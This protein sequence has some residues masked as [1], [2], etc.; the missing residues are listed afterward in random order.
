MLVT[1]KMAIKQLNVEIVSD[2]VTTCEIPNADGS[3]I[4]H[5]STKHYTVIEDVLIDDCEVWKIHAQGDLKQIAYL[6]EELRNLKLTHYAL[7]EM[8]RNY[9]KYDMPASKEILADR[10]NCQFDMQQLT[11]NPTYE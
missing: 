1:V 5:T 9:I 2:K 11:Y 8:N 7:L 10:L 4:S 6:E 3:G